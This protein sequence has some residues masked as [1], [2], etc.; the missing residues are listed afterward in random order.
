MQP[1]QCLELFRTLAAGKANAY[2]QLCDAFDTRTQ[3][4]QQMAHESKLLD[5]AVESI[6]RTFARRAAAALFSGRS[7]TLPTA[8]ETPTSAADLELITWLVIAEKTA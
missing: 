6:K 3:N 8:S 7:G 1:K 5:F 2:T 4:G